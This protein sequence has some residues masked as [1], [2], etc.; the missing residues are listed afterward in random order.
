[1]VEQPTSLS[2]TVPPTTRHARAR[3]LP[4]V[5][6]KPRLASRP[7]LQPALPSPRTCPSHP[8]H[9]WPEPP[10]LSLLSCSLLFEQYSLNSCS[11]THWGCIQTLLN[12]CYE[13]Y[14]VNSFLHKRA[15]PS[16]TL[17]CFPVLFWLFSFAA[18][19]WLS[20]CQPDSRSAVCGWVR[21][22]AV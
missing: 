12:S 13:P 5:M 10:S 15:L 9:L 22:L 7:L 11:S 4:L 19:L 6:I 18:F 21:E 14:Y 16:S 17:P 1:M 8:L 2:L 20:P 3:H